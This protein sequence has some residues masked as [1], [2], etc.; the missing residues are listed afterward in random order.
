[1]N[2]N[3]G[4]QIVGGF[5]GTLL[6]IVVIMFAPADGKLTKSEVA[7][8]YEQCDGYA[9]SKYPNNAGAWSIAAEA[10]RNQKGVK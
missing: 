7:A 2:S 3:E 1:M 6:L 9:E 5:I 4:K 10:C 8:V